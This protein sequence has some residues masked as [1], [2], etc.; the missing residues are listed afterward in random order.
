[1]ATQIFSPNNL[2]QNSSESTDRCNDFR[3]DLLSSTTG[4]ESSVDSQ[5]TQVASSLSANSAEF[6]Y[7]YNIGDDYPL[8]GFNYGTGEG[9]NTQ[10]Q[11]MNHLT[12]EGQQSNINFNQ[13]RNHR[14]SYSSNNNNEN[15]GTQEYNSVHGSAVTT[16]N[17]N[18]NSNSN[19]HIHAHQKPTA[20]NIVISPTKRSEHDGYNQWRTP[21]GL[22]LRTEGGQ[23]VELFVGIH[24]GGKNKASPSLI[25]KPAP[26]NT[27]LH[28]AKKHD[29]GQVDSTRSQALAP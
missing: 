14:N 18:Q 1:M 7:Q 15:S 27:I 8:D 20:I 22:L 24:Q 12:Q 6:S 25:S 17:T 13:S 4:S 28:P 26:G 3:V 16:G 23:E 10:H 2:K 9:V 19:S 21:S 11:Q 29:S 5:A